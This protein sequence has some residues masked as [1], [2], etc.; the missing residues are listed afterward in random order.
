MSVG[1]NSR[2]NRSTVINVRDRFG[3]LTRR[4]FLDIL[5]RFEDINRPDNRS[6]VVK[7]VDHWDS[8]AHRLYGSSDLWPVIAEFNQVI[9]PFDELEGGRELVLPSTNA[10][11]LDF[12]DFDVAFSQDLDIDDSSES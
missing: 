4:P 7:D 2:W 6:Y 8:L 9:N 1:P 3:K 10:V 12:L 11:F 5:P